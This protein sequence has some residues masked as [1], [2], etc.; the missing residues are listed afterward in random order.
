MPRRSPCS[1]RMARLSW[2]SSVAR[3]CCPSEL[4]YLAQQGEGRA[5]GTR[6]AR[7]ARQRHALLQQRRGALLVP[8]LVRRAPEEQQ[9]QGSRPIAADLPPERQALLEQ[10]A[11]PVELAARQRQHAEIVEGARGRDG[12]ARGARQR[13]PLVEQGARLDRSRLG[14]RRRTRGSTGRRRHPARLPAPGRGR[15][16]SVASASARSY[17]PRS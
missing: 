8:L 16:A 7:P 3:A 12:I 11:D 6:I 1:R 15:R 17:S 13:Q 14:S 4:R 5:G 10:R 2:N 9:R